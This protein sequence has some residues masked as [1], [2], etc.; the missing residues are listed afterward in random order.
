MNIVYNR[1]DY[2]E[3]RCDHQT[4]YRQFV[5]EFQVSYFFNDKKLLKKLSL[6]DE[7]LNGEGFPLSK[8][9]NIANQLVIGDSLNAIALSNS[10]ITVNNIK[11]ISL[12]DKVCT[13][14]QAAKMALEKSKIKKN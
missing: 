12:F 10:S 5:T 7:H 8:W 4:Y 2:I 6:L 3:K 1:K 9:D 14:N 13:I 11:T